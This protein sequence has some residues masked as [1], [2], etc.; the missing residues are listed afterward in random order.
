VFHDVVLEKQE[1]ATQFGELNR[2]HVTFLLGDLY[3]EPQFVP[4]L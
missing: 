4:L 1:S 3:L 2:I